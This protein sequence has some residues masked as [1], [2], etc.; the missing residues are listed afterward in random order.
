MQNRKTINIIGWTLALLTTT[1]YTFTMYPTLSFWDSGEFLTTAI[2]LQIGHPPGAPL[3]QIIGAFFSVFGFGNLGGRFYIS[4]GNGFECCLI[5]L[6]LC[7]DFEQ[8]FF[9]ATGQYHSFNN[10]GFVFCFCRQ[11]MVLGNRDRSVCFGNFVGFD[12]FLVGT[13]MG[14]YLKE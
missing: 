4:F 13:Q 6:E 1:L 5:V 3:Y 14:R 11:Y 7:E 2:T 8:V 10:R 12:D 9:Y